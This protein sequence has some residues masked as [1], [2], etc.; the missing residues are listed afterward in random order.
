MSAAAF[1]DAARALKRELTGDGAGLT[2]QEVDSLNAIILQWGADATRSPTA[3]VDAAAFYT[4]LR[5]AFGALGQ[6]QVDGFGALLQAFGTARWPLAFASYGLATAWHETNATMQPVREAYWLSEDW[7]RTH[8]R[9]YPWYGRGYVQLTWKGDDKQPHYGY[10]RADEELGLNGAL[11]ADPD[12][13]LKPDIAARIL[14][15]GMEHGWFCAKKLSDYLPL[16]GRAGFD[17][18]RE[19]RRIINGTDKAELIA[20]HAQAF[21]AAFIAGGWA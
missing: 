14:V 4:S 5:A 2:Q 3:L 20:K 13:A 11:L 7:R 18:Y 8:L 6:A 10:A 17:A 1:F 19:A 21:E 15:A 9:Y 12:L 16:S